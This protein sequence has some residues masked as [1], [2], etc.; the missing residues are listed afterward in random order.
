MSLWNFPW[1][2]FS[3]PADYEDPR[4]VKRRRIKGLIIGLLGFGILLAAAAGGWWWFSARMNTRASSRAEAFLAQYDFRSAQLTLEQAVQVNPGSVEARRALANFY[5][6]IGLARAVPRW[7][8]V[9]VMEEAD[10]DR[11]KLIESA[12]RF[13]EWD[14]AS[15]ALEEVSEAGRA[16]LSYHQLA[17]AVALIRRDSTVLGRHLA[18][19][20]RLAPGNARTQVSLASLRVRSPDQ[21]TAAAAWAELEALARSDKVRIHATLALLLSQSSSVSPGLPALAKRILPTGPA[22]DQAEVAPL[23]ALIAYMKAQP[24]PTP[25]DAAALVDWMATRGLS[26][27][28]LAWLETLDPASRTGPSVLSACANAAGQMQD[29]RLL[30]RYLDEGAWGRVNG[31]VLDLAFASNVQRERLGQSKGRATFGDAIELAAPSLPDLKVLDRLCALW[32][33]PEENEAV[34]RQMTVSFP[35]EPVAWAALFTVAEKAGKSA[36]FA[37]L[38]KDRAQAV[39]RDASTRALDLY[40][41][42]LVRQAN[43]TALETARSALLQSDALPDERAAGALLLLRENTPAEAIIAFSPIVAQLP[44]YPR[45][46][47]IYGIVLTAAGQTDEGAKFLALLP[48]E[49]RLPEEKKLLADA[50]RATRP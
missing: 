11:F 27:E 31:D 48:P 25:E 29:W 44:R 35:K 22:A 14:R 12:L 13:Q 34:W 16:T 24:Q 33:L 19:M 17:A 28:A 26:H 49:R 36:E 8:E 42:V 30:H 1:S 7:R 23:T 20:D 46:A 41:S 15:A 5:D 18:E 45:A 39:P 40:V 37:K 6:Q 10:A 47:F 9:V 21:A 32:R 4:L 43:P 38:A 50:T 2:R 3:S